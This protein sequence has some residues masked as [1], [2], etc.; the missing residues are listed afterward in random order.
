MSRSTGENS[1][2]RCKAGGD[3]AAEISTG[4]IWASMTT[5]VENYEVRLRTRTGR[6]DDA[7]EARNKDES[8]IPLLTYMNLF[9]QF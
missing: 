1:W 4:T 6:F 2:Q 3:G 9:L 7:Q 8:S 5:T